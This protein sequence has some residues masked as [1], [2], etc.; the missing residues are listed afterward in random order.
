[1]VSARSLIA[2]DTARREKRSEMLRG[3]KAIASH[4]GLTQRDVLYLIK[5]GTLPG[6]KI[7]NKFVADTETIE[8][9]FAQKMLR[10]LLSE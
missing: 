6:M 9:W 3:S 2:D 10:N 5:T 4:I 8:R 7:G 1:M